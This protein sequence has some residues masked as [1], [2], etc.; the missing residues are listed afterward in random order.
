LGAAAA[1]GTSRCGPQQHRLPLSCRARSSS[2]RGGEAVSTAG[3]RPLRLPPPAVTTLCS[4]AV[5]SAAASILMLPARG[6]FCGDHHE[7]DAKRC[8]DLLDSSV[9]MQ[10]PLSCPGL[11]KPLP[12]R[13]T[14]PEKPGRLSCESDRLAD[15]LVSVRAVNRG[16]LLPDRTS[17]T[18][19]RGFPPGP[20]RPVTAVFRPN[21]FLNHDH[22]KTSAVH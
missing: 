9:P 10:S 15:F 8:R 19:C 12:V 11:T 5:A 21:G 22:A 14:V 1:A 2:I 17:K 16:F 18:G 3:W 13:F 7:A 20:L 4:P 6:Q